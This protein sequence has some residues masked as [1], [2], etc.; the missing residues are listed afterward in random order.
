MSSVFFP[1]GRCR[2]VGV[3]GRVRCSRLEVKMATAA[4]AVNGA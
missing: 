1:S 2:G 3:G 4:A